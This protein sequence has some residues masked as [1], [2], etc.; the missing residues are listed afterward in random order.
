MVAMLRAT[1]KRLLRRVGLEVRRV[2]GPQG[3]L[4]PVI[5]LIQREGISLV[6]DVG[7]NAGQFANHLRHM[8]YR[9]R[10]VSF[11]PVADAHRELLKTAAGDDSWTV[12]PPIALGAQGG[13][14]SINVA[15]YSG[16]SSALP[17]S[18]SHVQAYAPSVT[19]ATEVVPCHRLDTVAEQYLRP[20]D[21]ALLKVDVQG[22]EKQVLQGAESL[23]QELRGV[24]IEVSL[25]PLY[26]G[27]ALAPDILDYLDRRGFEIWY[28]SPGWVNPHTGRMLQYDV[29]LARCAASN[30]ACN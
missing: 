9:G 29:L 4:G 22:F 12:A 2:R 24:Y 18:S 17:P 8:G 7:A 11:E 5:R 23:L 16:L 10:I 26:E 6:L 1:I 28:L 20:G 13:E 14:I 27:Q 19:I 3:P 21:R 25:Q 15:V 30:T